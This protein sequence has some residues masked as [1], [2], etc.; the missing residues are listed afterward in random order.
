LNT[1]IGEENVF[2][3]CSC[4]AFFFLGPPC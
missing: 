2:S 4:H 3:F 1:R